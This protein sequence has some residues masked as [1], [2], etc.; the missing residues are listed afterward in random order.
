VVAFERTSNS[1]RPLVRE[2]PWA[3]RF[4]DASH[5]PKVSKSYFTTLAFP[6]LTAMLSR[7]HSRDPSLCCLFYR[8]MPS[9]YKDLAYRFAMLALSPS[10]M[11]PAPTKVIDCPAFDA[12]AAL[13]NQAT[14]PEVH[15][16]EILSVRF[17]L[18][19]ASSF[20]P[21][22]LDRRYLD[23]LFSRHQAVVHAESGGRSI[24]ARFRQAFSTRSRSRAASITSRS[25]FSSSDLSFDDAWRMFE[26][27]LVG[28][29][30]S[31]YHGNIAKL[32]ERDALNM[33]ECLQLVRASHHDPTAHGSP[34]A[35]AHVL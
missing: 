4:V 8:S 6:T 16:S 25:S 24:M 12:I 1:C 29:V 31:T 26:E 22:A 5:E 23:E 19:A 17:E 30:L 21:C 20:S 32:R 11:P 35:V 2:G 10:D 9:T 28:R 7:H 3:A 18:P 14:A 33:L 13:N 27:V 15:H 34:A